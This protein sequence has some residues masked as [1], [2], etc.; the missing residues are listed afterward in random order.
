M[1]KQTLDAWKKVVESLVPV[2]DQDSITVAEFA[3]MGGIS[4]NFARKHL[5]QMVK[6]GAAVATKKRYRRSD[7]QIALTGSFKLKRAKA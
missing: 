3:I 1:K 5:E 2:D 4:P 6:S 7:G